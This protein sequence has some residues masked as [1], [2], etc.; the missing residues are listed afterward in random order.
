MATYRLQHQGDKNQCYVPLKRQLLQGPHSATSQ[1][2]AF[3]AMN[4]LCP[5][6]PIEIIQNNDKPELIKGK[7]NEKW[8]NWNIW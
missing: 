2:M 1:K 7:I 6:L 5:F 4:G 3:F 8:D